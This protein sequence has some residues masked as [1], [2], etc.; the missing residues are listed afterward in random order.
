MKKLLIVAFVFQLIFFLGCK[1]KEL[2]P[3][4]QAKME[5]Y[6]EKIEKPG[7]TFTAVNAQPMRGRTINLTSEYTLRV[8]KDTI[9]A[10]LPYFGRAYTAPMNPSDGGIRFRSTDFVYKSEQK[11]NGMYEIVIEPKDV[12]NNNMLRGLLLRLSVG[13]SGYGTLNVQSTNR[14]NISFYGTIE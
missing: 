2:T 9:D 4:Q 11:K 1:A 7:F 5:E 10:Y 13:V 6:A 8:S 12:D 14:Q 3:E